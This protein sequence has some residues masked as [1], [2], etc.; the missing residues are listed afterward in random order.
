ML[1]PKPNVTLSVNQNTDPSE[2]QS[3][4]LSLRLSEWLKGIFS[5]PLNFNTS[6][7][8]ET[9][10][11]IDFNSQRIYAVAL[12]YLPATPHQ[13][14]RYQLQS[15]ACV[16]T[17]SGAILDHQLQNMPQ[18]V[19]AL[20]ELRRLLKVRRRNVATAV[21][22]SSV[23]TKILHVP[24]SLPAEMLALH[25]QQAA[26]GQLP[27]PLADISLDFEMLKPC[28]LH[29]D[30][31]QVLLSAARTEHVQARVKALRQAG[32]RA[33]IV[34]IG[35]HA[36][37]RAVSFLLQPQ[38]GQLVATLELNT[39]SL[40]F[41]V[42]ADDEIIYQRL[43]P[44]AADVE[45]AKLGHPD[46]RALVVSQVQRQWQLFCSHSDQAPPKQL[47]LCGSYPELAQLVPLLNQL[48]GIA[49]QE[50]DFSRAFGHTPGIAP[51]LYSEAAAF[52]TALGL[53]L[54]R[55]M[56]CLT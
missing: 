5:R 3:E 31:D 15:M 45:E 49:V 24:N 32:W 20:G 16:A 39:E 54:R 10:L 55:D 23:T 2:K 50:P 19:L 53:A 1:S 52:S 40:T 6:T 37:A 42:L 4:K 12:R 7:A 11:G 13:P 43:Q 51:H 36:L 26:A 47:M 22:G 21:T 38:P 18:V 35:S 34:D 25:V 14:A 30:C 28:A 27:F 9:L 8:A 41:M 44:L 17:P 29:A 56:P 48:L 46:Y 33:Q